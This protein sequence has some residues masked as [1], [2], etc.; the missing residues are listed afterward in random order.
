[1]DELK[2]LNSSS[3][4]PVVA[5]QQYGCYVSLEDGVLIYVPMLA[6]GKADR[7]EHGQPRWAQATGS[8]PDFLKAVNKILNQLI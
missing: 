4:E 1:M 8:D 2:D 5:M 7:D 3:L 6:N